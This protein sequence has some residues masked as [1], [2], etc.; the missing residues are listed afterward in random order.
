[1]PIQMTRR[2]VGC[3]GD[4]AALGDQGHDEAEE[5]EAAAGD[6][7]EEMAWNNDFDGY[8]REAYEDDE[9]FPPLGVAGEERDAEHEEEGD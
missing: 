7:G 8:E 3:E 1:M 2:V 6:A 5:D 9:D 4:A